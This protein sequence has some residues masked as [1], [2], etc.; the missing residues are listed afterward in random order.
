MSGAAVY[1]HSI[2]QE[3]SGIHAVPPWFA[4]AI[5]AALQV[6]LPAALPAALEAA[7]PAA[8]EAALPA[9]L[10]P[11][12]QRLA[13]IEQRL[14]DIEE[15]LETI[16][17]QLIEASRL[18]AVAYNLQASDGTQRPFKTV[19]LPDGRDATL[20]PLNLPLLPNVAAVNALTNDECRTY[21]ECYH[22]GQHVPHLVARRKKMV[23]HAIGYLGL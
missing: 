7:L 3:M 13:A 12:N 18:S 16:E 2:A 21:V 6:A 4:P 1:E 9:A 20:T 11:T 15:T 10:Q 5:N 23:L 19:I 8:L 22:P 14:A 17:E